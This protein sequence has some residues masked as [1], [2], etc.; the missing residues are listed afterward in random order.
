MKCV[1]LKPSLP[2]KRK[3]VDLSVFTQT[4]ISPA[5]I[6]S[7]SQWPNLNVMCSLE[8]VSSSPCSA[9]AQFGLSSPRF[10]CESV[11][12]GP[13]GACW[14][15]HQNSP[16]QTLRDE[17]GWTCDGQAEQFSSQSGGAAKSLQEQRWCWMVQGLF[18]C[19]G[20][21]HRG[22]WIVCFHC[23]GKGFA[24]KAACLTKNCFCWEEITIK[25]SV[26][27][28][29]PPSHHPA[30]TFLFIEPFPRTFL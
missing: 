3:A 16:S 14:D 2:D 27:W 25:V 19:G 7:F 1:I 4:F 28:S 24:R 20:S 17:K 23:W 26:L 10:S 11:H 12:V 5:C 9:V 6:L 8:N 29:P 30:A 13:V 21:G 18:G 15:F 22:C